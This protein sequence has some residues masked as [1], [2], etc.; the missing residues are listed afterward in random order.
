M[1]VQSWLAAATAD[2]ERRGLAELEPLLETLARST[3]GLRKAEAA[4]DAR[5]PATSPPRQP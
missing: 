1:T 3:E 5:Q 4:L 2:A